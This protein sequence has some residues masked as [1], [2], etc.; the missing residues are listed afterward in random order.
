VH[1]W[2]IGAQ[3]GEPKRLTSGPWSL[4][5]SL[6]PGPLSSPIA[7]TPDGKSLILVRPDDDITQCAT[8]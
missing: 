1:L 4:P 5:S 2:L 3:G 8:H 6:P 7:W